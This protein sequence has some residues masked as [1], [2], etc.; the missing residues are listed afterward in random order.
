MGASKFKFA[1][2][3]SRLE[4]HRRVVVANWVQKQSEG[5]ISSFWGALQ[6]FLLRPSLDWMRPT[7]IIAGKQLYSIY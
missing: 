5:R 4:T 7:H 1:E 3:T 2:H 6:P